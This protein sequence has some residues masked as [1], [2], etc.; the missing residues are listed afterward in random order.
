MQE[1]NDAP[2]IGARSLNTGPALATQ[3]VHRCVSDVAGRDIIANSRIS[4]RDWPI[5]GPVAGYLLC[6]RYHA[7][8]FREGAKIKIILLCIKHG[9]ERA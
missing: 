2:W 6:N 5:Y 4:V 8:L 9:D 3:E 1:A 7:I